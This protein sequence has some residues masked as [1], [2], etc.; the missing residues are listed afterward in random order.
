MGTIF[1]IG[2]LLVFGLLIFLWAQTGRTDHQ[3]PDLNSIQAKN[4]SF[5]TLNEAQQEFL[6]GD[7][8]RIEFRRNEIHIKNHPLYAGVGATDTKEV[9]LEGAIP[10]IKIYE[11]G[12]YLRTYKIEP[13][14]SN[15]DLNNQIFDC[16]VRVHPDFSVQ[17]EGAVYKNKDQEKKEYI[18][19]QPFY[20]SN[21]NEKNEALFGRGMFA[22]GLHFSGYISS[23][24]I[25]LICICDVC[26]KSF[27]VDFYH[28]GFSDTQY[29]YS[30]NSMETLM[31]TYGDIE[32][33]PTQL[34]ENI[35]ENI[36]GEVESQL[37]KT[38]DGTFTYY[39]S[40]CCP[41]CHSPFNNFEKFKADRPKEYY[42]HFYLNKTPIY[43]QKI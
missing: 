9:L 26:E 16:E 21:K 18:R 12:K 31:V 42:A 32:N 39:N 13:K 17:I 14:D 38:F 7:H 41:H 22:R 8:Q 36:L 25:R 24:D 27:S 1:F 33:M 20:L 37:P 19:F 2:I 28:A 4:E 6:K 43:F 3:N 40:F 15:P 29:F 35:D 30:S 5:K 11:N 23:G 34:Q 10:E